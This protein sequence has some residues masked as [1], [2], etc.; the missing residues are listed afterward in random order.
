MKKIATIIFVITSLFSSQLFAQVDC[1]GYNAVITHGFQFT[2]GLFDPSEEWPAKMAQAISSACSGPVRIYYYDNTTNT[3]VCDDIQSKGACPEILAEASVLPSIFVMD[4]AAASNDAGEGFSEAAADALFNSLLLEEEL[5]NGV[6]FSGFLHFIGHSRGT[7]VNSD[8]VERLLSIGIDVDQ[9]TNLDPHD[10]GAGVTGFLFATDF[11]MNPYLLDVGMDDGIV[12]W[13]PIGWSDSYYQID[14]GPAEGLFN[15][16][17]GRNI[18]GTNNILLQNDDNLLPGDLGSCIGHSSVHEWYLGTILAVYGGYDPDLDPDNCFYNQYGR[19]AA[20]DSGFYFTTLLLSDKCGHGSSPLCNEENERTALQFGFADPRQGIINGDGR[21]VGAPALPPPG[22]RYFGGSGEKGNMPGGGVVD[23]ITNEKISFGQDGYVEHNPLYI[24][25]EATGIEIDVISASSGGTLDV[26]LNGL[27]IGQID[28]FSAPTVEF[29]ISGQG[30]A[31][32]AIRLESNNIIAEVDNIRFRM[33]PSVIIKHPQSFSYDESSQTLS[34]SIQSNSNGVAGGTVRL[35]WSKNGSTAVP[36]PDLPLGNSLHAYQFFPRTFDL[37]PVSCGDI[38]TAT[39]VATSDNGATVKGA[40]GYVA[41][42][43]EGSLSLTAQSPALVGSPSTIIATLLGPLGS[44]RQGQAITFS[45]GWSGNFT[46]CVGDNAACVATTDVGGSV[47][48]QFTSGVQGT[49][50]ITASEPYGGTD[51]ALVNFQTGGSTAVA[52]PNPVE[53]NHASTVTA[54]LTNPGGTPV[55]VGTLVQF[56]TA[57]PGLFSPGNI[58][59]STTATTDGIGQAKVNFTP[60]ATGTA[61]IT[62]SAS[63]FE[64]IVV[65]LQVIDSNADKQISLNIS[66]QS[67]ND[68]SSAYQIEALVTNA[69]GSPVI[70]EPVSFALL[71]GNG[72]LRDDYEIT[73]ATGRAKVTLDVYFAG[74][75]TVSATAGTA[76]ASQTFIAQIGS[77]TVSEMTPVHTFNLNNRDVYGLDYSPD[78]NSLYAATDNG[79]IRGWHTSNYSNKFTPFVNGSDEPLGQLSVRPDNNAFLVAANDAMVVY[80]ASTGSEICSANLATGDERVLAAWT[81]SSSWLETSYINIQR[82]TSQCG[83]ASLTSAQPQTD[84]YFESVSHFDYHSGIG[85]GAVSTDEGE[86]IVVNSTGGLVQRL[87][88][89]A[90]ANAHDTDFSADGS[91]LVAVGYN[92]AKV[93][94]TSNWSVFTSYS[95]PA[96]GTWKYGVTFM[97]NDQKVALGGNPRLEIVDTATGASFRYA[98]LDSAAVEMDW[99]QSTEELAVGT[100]GGIV[101]IFQPLAPVDVI[102]PIISIGTPNVDAVTDLANIKTSGFVTDNVAVT[103]FTINGTPVALGPD[104]SFS[105]DIPLSAGENTIN[106]YA[107]D[108]AGNSSTTSRSVTRIVDTIP[109]AISGVSV[110][111]T[112]GFI[113]ATFTIQASIIDGDTGVVSAYAKIKTSEGGVI[114]TLSMTNVGGSTYQAEFDSTGY[115][116]GFYSVDIEATDA[117]PDANQSTIVDA[118]GFEVLLPDAIFSDGFESL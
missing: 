26:F 32:H 68:S 34:V 21:R 93:F 97:D 17:S 3:F 114:A 43:S 82:R 76:T 54:T 102:D 7:A 37:S 5:N 86:V 13:Q 31:G 87:T 77:G 117:S 24:P 6:D 99:N 92:S 75:T 11:D 51:N 38:V 44:P 91:K 109:P 52:T 8:V 98:T 20:P 1:T 100:A 16:L 22:Y 104:G 30:T 41:N 112:Q 10:W 74:E 83:S 110:T 73:G 46:G 116:P 70:G 33:K 111:P 118:T 61:Q 29:P 48:V 96:L 27:L 113:G 45:T 23:F 65:P 108:A 15:G 55:P 90:G 58:P 107:A 50:V 62:V 49:A 105:T 60:H 57:H 39:A 115:L 9:V 103:T 2:G 95:P 67:G 36:T 88:L 25:E 28:E 59:S 85:R 80:S 71:T 106:Y 14:T 40:P 47:S 18:I 53:L 4:W 69:Q 89:A 64:S 84:H 19:P 72:S 101:Y 56:S 42:C 79:T 63:G 94:N 78:G 81:S 66:Y 12:A 35:D